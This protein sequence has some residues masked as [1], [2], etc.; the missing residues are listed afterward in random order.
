MRVLLFGYAFVGH[1]RY[2]K[3]L[4]T[5]SLF[6]RLAAQFSRSPVRSPDSLLHK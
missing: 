2:T 5:E 1:S 4:F 6:D 3:S